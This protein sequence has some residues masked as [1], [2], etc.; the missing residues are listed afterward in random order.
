MGTELKATAS[1]GARPEREA[2]VVVVGAGPT[3]LMLA[4][5]LALVGVDVVAVER[6]ADQELAGARARGLM[7]RTLEVL[8]QRGIVDRFLAEGETM[9]VHTFGPVTLD[10]SAFPTRHPYGLALAQARVEQI[11]AGWVDELPVRFRRGREVTD[12]TQDESGVQVALDDGTALRAQYVVGCDGGR[13][14]VRRAA[15]IAFEGWEAT[16]SYMIAELQLRDTPTLGFTVNE[17]GRHAI[18]PLDD[19]DGRYAMV[20]QELP[21]V[22]GEAPTLDELRAGAFAVWGTDFGLHSP[23]WLSRFSD[24]A[25]QA[26]SYREGR[27]LVAGDAA[28][29]HSPVGGQGLNTGVQDAVNLGWKLAQVVR[30][31]SPESLLDTYHAERHPVGARVLQGTLATTAFIAGDPRA[32]ALRDTLS[33]VLALD[34]PRRHLAGR[35]SG[36]D[37]HYD[38]GDGHPLVG[39]RMPDL[40]VTTADGSVRLFTLLHD[41]RPALVDFGGA[42]G[43]DLDAWADRVR[44]IRGRYD[45]PWELPVLGVVDGPPAVLI[46][47]DGYVA[48]A[49]ALD[50]AELSGALTTWFGPSQADGGGGPKPAI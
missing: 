36:L 9:Q 32:E 4:G 10:L 15:G 3:G 30:G 19:G 40:E 41:A 33:S 6:R 27:V 18:G 43:V 21:A 5:E 12:V 34:E 50:D 8:D 31:T 39:R 2:D 25:R 46:R 20:V 28:H 47:P 42:G 7:A 29:V 35:F 1:R 38:L 37:I 48:W 11:L 26:T 16:T 44:F 24:A 23:T 14:I 13:S 45:G 22:A 49:G 17:Q